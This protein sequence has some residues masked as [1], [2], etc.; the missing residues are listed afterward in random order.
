MATIVLTFDTTPT[1]DAKLAK[2][3]AFTN[4]KRLEQGE[5]QYTSIEE[6]LTALAVRDVKGEIGKVKEVD[7]TEVADAYKE[8]SSASQDSVRTTLGLP[9]Y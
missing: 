9:V 8:A 5:T 1:Q 4:A 7:A 6:W 3:F 2:A